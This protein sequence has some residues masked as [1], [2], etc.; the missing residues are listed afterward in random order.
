MLKR[1]ID[2]SLRN[3]FLVLLGTLALV[4]GRRLYAVRNTPLDA[5]SPTSPTCASDHLH[6]MARPGAANRAGPGYLPHHNQNAFRAKRD[7]RARLFIL[8]LFFCVRDFQGR[9]RPVLGTQPRARILEQPRQPACPRITPTVFRPRTPPA[10]ATGVYVFA[11]LHQP[12]PRRIALDAGLV[13][14]V[15]NRVG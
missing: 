11:Q 3:K 13:S 6:G 8:R 12:R 1:I 2:F 7:G 4:S 9:H 15:S 10:W 14:P 5:V